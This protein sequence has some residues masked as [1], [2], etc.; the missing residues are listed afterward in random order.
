MITSTNSMARSFLSLLGGFECAGLAAGSP[1]LTRK[2]RALMAYLALQARHSQSREKIAAL[3][4][5]GAND[6][7]ARA[8]LR[9][10]LSVLRR[11]LQT[12]ERQWFRIE[13]DQL[14]LDLHEFDL[15]VTQFELL[16]ASSETEDLKQAIAL[17]SGEL[18]EGFSLA[19]E[20]FEDWLRTERERLRAVAIAVLEKLIVRETAVGAC[21][22]AANRLLGLDPLREDIHRIVMSAYE[23]QGRINLALEQYQRLSDTLRKQLGVQPEPE[24]RLLYEKLVARRMVTT[25]ECQ[26]EEA[27]RSNTAPPTHYVKSSGVNIAYQVTGDGP[28]DL[29]YVQGWVSN[30]DYAWASTRLARTLHRL[31]SFCRLIRI[32]KRGTGL[33]DRTAG[34]PTL[35]ERMQDV[36][37]VLDAVGSRSAV[38][39][40]SSEGGLMCMLFAASYPERTTALILHGAYARGLWSPDYPWG[41]TENELE[42]ELAAIEREWGRAADLSRAAPSLVDDPVEREWF[43]AYLRNSASPKDAISLWRWS[44]EIDA[45]DILSAIRV[46]TLITHRTGDRWVH[47]DEGRY[48]A[49]RIPHAKYVELP[50]DDHVIWG[51]DSDRLIDEIQG[52][53]SSATPSEP[54]E[55]TLL[56]VVYAIIPEG[57]ACENPDSAAS[58]RGGENWQ[59]E[60]TRLLAATVGQEIELDE[61]KV[62]A[63]FRQPMQ[64][65]NY[66]FDLRDRLRCKGVDVR[67]AIHIGECKRQG[68]HC[69][70][71]VMQLAAEFAA[72]PSPGEIFASQTVRDLTVGAS[73]AFDRRGQF[74][75]PG[76]PGPWM[77]FSV[78]PALNL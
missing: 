77:F 76:F 52:F 55:S 34:L 64:A 65:I 49:S 38:L 18:L 57:Y 14:G 73:L 12:T 29:V 5:G 78:E 8:S 10:T 66:A 43:A 63:G 21:I 15:D 72:Y 54:F 69:S 30:L 28:F 51:A 71:P 67:A 4:W 32:D 41:R 17:Y 61:N 47:P 39:F 70:G 19:E 40:G 48:L 45:R 23:K 25:K 6:E 62:V 20:P 68:N 24:T 13:G 44:V 53:L 3:L 42:D 11:A 35:E 27:R 22:A 16:A 75:L 59:R 37:A 1:A 2:A 26:P 56:T 36:R 74:D 9:Q 46:P 58:G 33:S 50:G 7:Q 60:A 31:G